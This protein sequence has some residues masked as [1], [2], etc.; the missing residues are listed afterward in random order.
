MSWREVR[1]KIGGALL[2]FFVVMCGWSATAQADYDLL[3]RIYWCDSD[4]RGV[5]L[6]EHYVLD[7]AMPTHML[8][9]NRD[10]EPAT[11]AVLYPARG[12]AAYRGEVKPLLSSNGDT[13]VPLDEMGRYGHLFV[14]RAPR[15][16]EVEVP[17][18]GALPTLT[19][20]PFKD[21]RYWRNY[22]IIHPPQGWAYGPRETFWAD[23]FRPLTH[24]DE[25]LAITLIGALCIAYLYGVRAAFICLALLIFS[26]VTQHDEELLYMLSGACL[27][28]ALLW[29][30]MRWLMPGMGFYLARVLGPA[31]VLGLV[32]TL[33]VSAYVEQLSHRVQDVRLAQKAALLAEYETEPHKR[34]VLLEDLPQETVRVMGGDEQLALGPL[35]RGQPVMPEWVTHSSLS[36]VYGAREEWHDMARV[37]HVRYKGKVTRQKTELVFIPPELVGLREGVS[38]VLLVWLALIV[39]APGRFAARRR[40]TPFDPHLWLRRVLHAPGLLDAPHGK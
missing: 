16:G 32:L 4:M 3:D 9:Q 13:L 22:D 8:L 30:L 34:G 25:Q 21:D 7:E 23:M 35:G 27:A 39:L 11:R 15:L 20:M 33:N 37:E 5:T 29:R 1:G 40:W 36:D 14:E 26:G 19:L 10:W 18:W 31:L 17:L 12:S 38:W 6:H 28:P 2:S 24:N